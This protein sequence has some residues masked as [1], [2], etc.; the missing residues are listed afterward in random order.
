MYYQQ[1]KKKK[2]NNQNWSGLQGTT[3]ML[4]TLPSSNVTRLAFEKHQS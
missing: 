2:N 3:S 1:P 4:K